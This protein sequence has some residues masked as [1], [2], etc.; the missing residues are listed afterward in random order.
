MVYACSE[1]CFLDGVMCAG[2]REK[3][4]ASLDQIVADVKQ[5]KERQQQAVGDLTT[6]PEITLP[7]HQPHHLLLPHLHPAH[8]STHGLMAMSGAGLAAGAAEGGN[9]PETAS[10]SAPLFDFGDGSD[11]DSPTGWVAHCLESC[12]FFSLY[13]LLSLSLDKPPFQFHW[14]LTL[15]STFSA[16]SLSD[17]T[18]S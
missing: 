18:W 15:F 9:S 2:N 11:L 13:N 8:N 17:N 4:L 3:K 16:W 14:C 7:Y 1:I 6:T 5:Q 10:A 12:E